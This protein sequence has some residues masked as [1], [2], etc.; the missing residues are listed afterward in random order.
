[1]TIHAYDRDRLEVDLH[2]PMLDDFMRSRELY[3]ELLAIGNEIKG[4]YLSRVPR[5]TSA[6]ASTAQVKMHRSTQ[7]RDRRWE[8]EFSVGNAQVDYADDIED[9]FHPLAETLR[10]LGYGDVAI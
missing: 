3:A 8:A 10:A 7:Y 9:E 4:G 1:M 6:L 5:D 2:G